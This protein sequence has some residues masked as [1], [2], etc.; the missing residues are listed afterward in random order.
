MLDKTNFYIIIL[1]SICAG[2]KIAIVHIVNV[3]SCKT[4][5]I[6]FPREDEINLLIELMEY[7]LKFKQEATK[8]KCGSIFLEHVTS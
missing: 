4:K 8:G 7:S 1:T 3:T 6:K 2:L 5:P